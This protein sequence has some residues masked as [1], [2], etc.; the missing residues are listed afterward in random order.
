[1]YNL[2]KRTALYTTDSYISNYGKAATYNFGLAGT[3]AIPQI[4]G[5]TWGLD[6]GLKHAF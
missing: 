4:G 2:S 1:M 3:P 6:F 5:N